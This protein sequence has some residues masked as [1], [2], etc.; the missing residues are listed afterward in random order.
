MCRL[1]KLFFAPGEEFKSAVIGE[2]FRWFIVKV[3]VVGDV[4]VNKTGGR[5]AGAATEVPVASKVTDD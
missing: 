1:S 5:D 3:G 2:I 4:S